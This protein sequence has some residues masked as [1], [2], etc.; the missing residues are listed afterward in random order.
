[1]YTEYQQRRQQLMSKIGNGTA[2]FCSAPMA[3][4][5]N[6]VE[7]V[8]RQDSD[9]FYLTGFN[10]A[11]AVAVLAPHHPE[12]K[13]VLFVQPKNRQIEIWTGYRCGVDAAKEIYGADE[14]YSIEELDEKLPKYLKQA[15][16]IYYHLGRDRNFN[17]KVLN[18]WQRL[19]RIYPK[20]GVGPTAIE[21]TGPIL[22]GMRLIKSEAELELMRKAADISVEA[23]NRAME[24]TQPGQYE[25]EVQAEMEHIF[26]LRGGMGPAYP[27]IVASADNACIL[28]YIENSRQMQDGEL[29]L[30]D[31]GCSYGYY[32][33]DIT[34]TFPVGGKFTAEQKALYELVLEAQKQAI[35][36]VKPGNPY[37]LIH[38]TAVKV[39]TEGLV[40]LG[41]L[42]G[43]VEQLIEEQ[44]YKPFYMHGTGHWL[45]L[46]VHDVGVYKYGEDNPQIL[47][48]GQVLTVE[49]G[50]YIVPDT[51][52]DED[53]PEIDPRWV[54]IGIRIEDDV[55]VTPNGHEV[56]TAGV[57]KEIADIE[58]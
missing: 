19:M 51:E 44:K 41:L 7:Y 15:D 56:L 18:H 29:L 49:P 4:M 5:H 12:H 45:G 24:F 25:Y 9:F 33:S 47:Q 22:H 34:R 16:R 50:L 38:D 20:H 36:Q 6:D 1:M 57:P 21:D 40:E 31:A 17:D 26:R 27:S 58:K 55:L 28:H 42:V 37:N 30:I 48:P 54:G 46:D 11:E 52:P 14:A 43:E 3:V 23:H 53:Q 35:A 2:I 39:L 32:N 8:F 13:Y 10:E